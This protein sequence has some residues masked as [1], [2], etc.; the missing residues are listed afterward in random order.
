MYSLQYMFN[1]HYYLN[2]KNYL[3]KQRNVSYLHNLISNCTHHMFLIYSL[4]TVNQQQ[5]NLM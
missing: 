3:K 5:Y 1:I 2:V 4:S